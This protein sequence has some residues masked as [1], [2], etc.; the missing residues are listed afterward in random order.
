MIQATGDIGTQWMLD[1][2]NDIVRE[3]LH[4]RGLEVKCG[5]TNLQRER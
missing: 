1:L 5:T 4:A 3:R 2:C